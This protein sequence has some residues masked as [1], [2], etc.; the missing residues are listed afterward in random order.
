MAFDDQLYKIQN[1]WF[2]I[3]IFISYLTY[4][5][6][7][8]GFFTTAPQYLNKLDYYVKIYV[9]L[10]LLW[11]FNPFRKI[12]FTELDRK[13]SFSAGIFLLTT[14]TINEI[15]IRYF[16]NAKSIFKQQK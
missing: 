15:I 14:T 11:R 8:I 10:F 3:F 5:L 13:I 1:F 7:A 12:Q 6:F 9:S 16:N 2:N 4:I